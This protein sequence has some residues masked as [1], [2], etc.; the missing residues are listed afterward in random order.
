MQTKAMPKITSRVG[1]GEGGGNREEGSKVRGR[2]SDGF[3]P[4][5]GTPAGSLKVQS[6]SEG[7]GRP[8]GLGSQLRE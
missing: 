4:N 6:S 8:G 1:A 7:L 5:V 2:N 3:I